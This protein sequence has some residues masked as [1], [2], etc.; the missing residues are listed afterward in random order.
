MAA[1]LS[2]FR[3]LCVQGGMMSPKSP[4]GTWMVWLGGVFGSPQSGAHL[5]DG[6]ASKSAARFACNLVAC[7]VPVLLCCSDGQLSLVMGAICLG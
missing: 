5:P 3:P 1:R 6:G 7:V 2:S 4:V